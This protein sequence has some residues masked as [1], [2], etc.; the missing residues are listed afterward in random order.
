MGDHAIELRSDT[1]TLP[2]P[3]MREAMAHAELGD[4]VYGEDPTVRRLEELAAHRLGKAAAC[5]MPSGTMANLSSLL[6]HCARGH[7]LLVGDESDIY[8]YEAGGASALGGLVYH[9]LPTQLDGTI[10]LRD[11]EQGMRDAQ[12]P[13]CARAGV[14][15]LEDT[16]NRCGGVVLSL[17]YLRQVRDFA[18]S[19]RLPVHLDGARIF[20]AAVA[21]GVPA[22]AIAQYADSVQFCLS[23]GL[24]APVGSMVVGEAS[25]IAE[26][27][28]AR[29]MLGG[30]MRQAGIIAAAGI[31]ALEQ[32]ADRLVEDH[33]HARLLAEGLAQNRGIAVDL[34]TVQTNI[35]LFRVTDERFTCERFIE[36]A[37]QEG[38]H[39]AEFGHGRIRAVTHYGITA[40]DIAATITAFEHVVSAS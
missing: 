4:D 28:R 32:M 24:A 23:K 21:L 22:A 10:T 25:F 36:L 27:R 38:I 8:L 35:V 31:V 12:D 17:P 9:P 5:L 18:R 30:G 26:V 7:E 20:N 3:A 15:C 6:A 1:F 16:H 39:V 40:Q 14:I 2:S 34:E 11:L 37:W 19:H 13:Q 33:A 29:K